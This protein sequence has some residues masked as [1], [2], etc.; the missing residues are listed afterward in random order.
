MATTSRT[1]QEYRNP[2]LRTSMPPGNLGYQW[3]SSRVVDASNYADVLTMI[4]QP[5]NLNSLGCLL[6]SFPFAYTW[7][8]DQVC[9]E[10]ITAFSAG[11]T[12][13]IGAGTIATDLITTGGVIT[14]NSTSTEIVYMPPADITA[15]TAALY[16]PLTANS[17]AWLA[18]KVAASSVYPYTITGV[19]YYPG[20]VGTVPV[21]Y[22]FIYN[23]NAALPI[24]GKMRVHM[25]LTVIPALNA[26]V[27]P[28][29]N[30]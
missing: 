10:V 15:T 17:S 9:C 27:S 12:I 19:N 25:L 14:M 18:A 23:A 8:V 6:F 1:I 28:P 30:F 21:V 22:A 11:T 26:A 7:Y 4:P 16:S 20:A 3:I 5:V 29:D 13:S 24:V 2:A